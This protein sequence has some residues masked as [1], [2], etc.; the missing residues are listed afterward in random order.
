MA[1]VFGFFPV[2]VAQKNK[3]RFHTVQLKTTACDQQVH[4]ARQKDTGWPARGDM[5]LMSMRSFKTFFFIS[6][7]PVKSAKQTTSRVW[8]L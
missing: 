5:Y 3:G 6:N 1:D 7:P 4:H 8:S 2:I